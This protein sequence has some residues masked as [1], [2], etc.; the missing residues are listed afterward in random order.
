MML[1]G[2]EREKSSPQEL[3]ILN[4]LYCIQRKDIYFISL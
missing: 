3:L 4:E 2:K 1:V